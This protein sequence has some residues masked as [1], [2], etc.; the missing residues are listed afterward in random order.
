MNHKHVLI[1][2]NVYGYFSLLLP[3]FSCSKPK[4][5]PTPWKWMHDTISLS[6]KSIPSETSLWAKTMLVNMFRTRYAA[7]YSMKKN[8]TNLYNIQMGKESRRYWLHKHKI[9]PSSTIISFFSKIQV[10]RCFTL[11][12]HE[13]SKRT[14]HKINPNVNKRSNNNSINKIFKR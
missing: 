13:N 12:Y 3:F 7:C 4:R 11:D 8:S 6:C 14:E 1:A 10:P 9:S 5:A 2:P